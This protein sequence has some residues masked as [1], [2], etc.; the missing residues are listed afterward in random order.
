MLTFQ[1]DMSKLCTH[2]LLMFMGHETHTQGLLLYAGNQL[3]RQK[4]SLSPPV[5]QVPSA[6][7]PETGECL[8]DAFL[9][10]QTSV[11]NS[12]LS[13][14]LLQKERFL[15]PFASHVPAAGLSPPET[16]ITSETPSSHVCSMVVSSACTRDLT[17]PYLSPPHGPLLSAR[18]APGSPA[19]CRFPLRPEEPLTVH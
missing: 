6:G 1:A 3:L 7:L 12:G 15:K 14:R 8:L 17:S 2:H 16:K 11:L 4:G 9:K 5:Q 19:G 10:V 13:Y 18:A